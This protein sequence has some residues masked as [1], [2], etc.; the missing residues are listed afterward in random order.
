MTPL[1]IAKKALQDIVNFP[2]DDA[3]YAAICALTDIAIAEDDEQASERAN[4]RKAVVRRL[5]GRTHG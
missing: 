2:K 4:E 5:F 3:Q 1:E